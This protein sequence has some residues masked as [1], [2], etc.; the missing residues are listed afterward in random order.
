[1]SLVDDIF[2]SLAG[3][4][5]DDWGIPAVYV[6][7][8]ASNEYDPAL[9]TYG[10][11]VDPTTQNPVVNK[12]RI[13]INILPCQL[14]ADEVGGEVQLTDIKILIAPDKLGSYYPR[15]KD[16]IEYA[17]DGV[18]RTAKIIKPI[19]YRGTKPVFHSV[20]ARLG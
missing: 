2:D 5:I 4:L 6:K 14:E 7:H 11:A 13:R 8:A 20:I 10:N 16:W 9:G 17:Q 19:T 18:T 3:P 12:N 1:M 15:T